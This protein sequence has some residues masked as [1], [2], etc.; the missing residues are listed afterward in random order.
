MQNESTLEV[1]A[2]HLNDKPIERDEGISAMQLSQFYIA[3]WRRY[4]VSIFR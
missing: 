2:L 4:S 3:F 1:K